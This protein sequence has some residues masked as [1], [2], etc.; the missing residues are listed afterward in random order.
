MDPQKNGEE[1]EKA[2]Y[3]VFQGEELGAGKREGYAKGRIKGEN[4]PGGK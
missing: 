1:D 2:P 3:M 4:I